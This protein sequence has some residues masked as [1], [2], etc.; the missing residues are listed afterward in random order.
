MK[1]SFPIQIKPAAILLTIF[2]LI[3]AALPLS[4]QTGK[5]RGKVTTYHQNGK[6]KS[7]G[8]V[9]NYEEQGTWKFW[10][11]QEHLVRVAE[12]RN[13]KL[14][15]IYTEYFSNGKVSAQGTYRDDLREGAWTAYHPS[16]KKASSENYKNGNF[17]GLQQSYYENGQLKEEKLYTNGQIVYRLTWFE[18]GRKRKVENYKNGL[19]EGTWRT[20]KASSSD[21]M[22]SV[23]DE[24]VGGNREGMHIE[25]YE[26]KKTEE[27]H[28][29]NDKR[30]GQSLHWNKNGQ[31]KSSEN[32]VDG[33][34]DGLCKYYDKGG[35]LTREAYYTRGKQHGQENIY[36]HSAALT[37]T[38]WYTYNQLDSSH[39]FYPNGKIETT[40][41]YRYLPG[42][43]YTEQFSTYSEY[44]STGHLLLR[45]EYHFETKNNTW[46]TYYPDGKV[47]SQ[48]PYSGGQ[49]KGTYKKWYANG[50]PLIEME[51]EGNQ[52]MSQPKIWDAK[53]KP[54]KP[55]TKAYEELLES[56]KPGEVY[57]DP[58]RYRGNRTELEPPPVSDEVW[59]ATQEGDY[60]D[61]E[62][63]TPTVEVEQREE[64]VLYFAEQMPE[65]PATFGTVQKFF[66]DSLR[67]PVVEKEA[68]KQG[69]VYVNFI[70][71]RDGSITNVKVAKGVPGAPGLDK[72]AVRL[73]SSMPKWTPAKM[74][75][76]TVRCSTTIPV[77][78]VLQ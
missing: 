50:K 66:Q 23:T 54:L 35:L 58:R 57:N 39:T 20:Y 14:N 31:L 5:K 12:Y 45:G 17:E 74:N 61:Y 41:V 70:V 68:G 69:T 72:E 73:V 60:G 6:K 71:E 27:T 63:I 34:R 64:E 7:S 11:S 28:Y 56:S 38:N 65:F 18:T 13:G 67:Y 76:R 19:A 24:Y 25:Y 53:G 75:G 77:K 46:T 43:V 30:N 59:P 52:V 32:Y 1:I 9:K 33:L 48:T 10:D 29:S 8:K 4:A 62:V 37:K 55:G 40:R 44:D 16:G 2:L 21:T 22:P 42:F 36:Y 3:G 26:G 51:C 47:K 49:I 78:F 15:G